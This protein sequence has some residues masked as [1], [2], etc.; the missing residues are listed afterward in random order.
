MTL[1]PEQ[2]RPW[3]DAAIEQAEKSWSEGGIPIGAVLVDRH[4]QIVAR[5]HNERV[6]SGDPTAHGEMSCIRQAG[7]RRDWH[8]LTLVT[9][10]SPCPMCAGTTVLYRIP[11][12]VIGECRTFQGAESWL[13]EAGVD[14]IHADCDRCVSLM[15]RL[16]AEKPDLWAEDIGH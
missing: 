16:Q 15:E 10:L 2:W 12:V 3:L 11:R 9:T 14:L 13:Q 8:E 7:R 1:N 4:G 5:G 6:Q